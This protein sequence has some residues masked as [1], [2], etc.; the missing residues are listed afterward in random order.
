[1][2]YLTRDVA[3]ALK[4]KRPYTNLNYHVGSSEDLRHPTVEALITNFAVGQAE[5]EAAE[6]AEQLAFFERA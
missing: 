6:V 3:E 4:V 5:P 1:M 2:Y